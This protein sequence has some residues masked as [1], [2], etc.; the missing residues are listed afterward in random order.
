MAV[1][2]ARLGTG[3]STAPATTRT[4]CSSGS[5]C[6]NAAPCAMATSTALTAGER[7]STPSLRATRV[8]TLETGSFGQTLP[9]R[10]R[11]S[12]R[13]WKKRA[14]STPYGCLRTR[15]QEKDR[16]SADAARGAALP[17]Q[18]EAVLRGFPLSGGVPGQGAPRHRQDRMAPG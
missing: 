18:G 17:D 5:A 7:F 8:A 9:M 11:H 4:S 2:K 13:G 14:V 6:W 15:A 16:A 10:S 12:M 1:R 3:I